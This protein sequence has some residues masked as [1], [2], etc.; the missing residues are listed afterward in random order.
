[1]FFTKMGTLHRGDLLRCVLRDFARFHINIQKTFKK[2]LKKISHET[3]LI[4]LYGNCSKFHFS[5]KNQ[6]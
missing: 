6:A 2:Y 3:F 1:M 4:N 5:L